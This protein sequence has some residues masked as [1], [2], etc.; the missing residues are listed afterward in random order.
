MLVGIDLRSVVSALRAVLVFVARAGRATVTVD[1]A[2]AP[3]RSNARD[4][5][6]D[7]AVAVRVPVRARAPESVRVAAVA[8][9]ATLVAVRDTTDASRDVVVAE[10]VRDN[11]S[12]P[13]TAA[14]DAPMA[15]ASATI[16]TISFFISV[17]YRLAKNENVSQV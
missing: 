16:E 13:R 17:Q 14:D 4:D 6:L 2:R 11:E 10:F 15:S 1:V 3:R 5:V 8:R 9:L 7:V 12:V